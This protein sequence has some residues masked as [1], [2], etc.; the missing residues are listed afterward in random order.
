MDLVVHS[1]EPIDT[2]SQ[3]VPSLFSDVSQHMTESECNYNEKVYV[4]CQLMALLNF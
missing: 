4:T 3:L 2:L 1:Q